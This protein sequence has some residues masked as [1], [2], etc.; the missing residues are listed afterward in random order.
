MKR[1]PR[2]YIAAL[3]ISAL[4]DLKDLLAPFFGAG[5]RR[6][7]VVMVRLGDEPVER[8]DE[9]V[10]AGLFGSRS[11][12]AAFLV[13][14]GIHAQRELFARIAEQTSEL[15]RLR[16]LLHQTAR[17]ALRAT[18]PP[19]S[20]EPAKAKPRKPKGRGSAEG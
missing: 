1:K 20:P 9:L 15:H 6:D 17:E 4:P 18:A 2:A 8:L 13:G 11:E 3:P 19:A 16:E 12:A 10:E 7:N 14:A 5:N